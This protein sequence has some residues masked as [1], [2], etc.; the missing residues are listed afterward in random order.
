MEH[1]L[2]IHYLIFCV[3]NI[4]R[5]DFSKICSLVDN[6][7]LHLLK[8]IAIEGD[9]K[10]SKFRSLYWAIFL[11]VLPGDSQKWKEQRTEQRFAYESLK[12]RYAL[13]PHLDNGCPDDPLSQDSKVIDLFKNYRKKYGSFF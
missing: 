10:A 12:Q 6:N 13:N 7:K 3:S 1:L 5:S 4:Y 8:R 11:D 9:L 2:Y